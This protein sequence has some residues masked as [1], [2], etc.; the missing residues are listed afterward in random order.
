MRTILKELKLTLKIND[1]LNSKLWNDNKKLKPEV[2]MALDK[3]G[4]EWADFANIPKKA[5]KDVI[6]TGGNANTR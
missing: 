3:I 4:K 5:I 1:Q 6:I 2:W